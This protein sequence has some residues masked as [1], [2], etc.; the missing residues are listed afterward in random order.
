V[1]VREVFEGD[2]EPAG[3]A[4]FDLAEDLGGVV[5]SC[6]RLF[7]YAAATEHAHDRFIS[8]RFHYHARHAA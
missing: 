1:A 4:S 6:L 2:V 8:S 3:A 5:L 7:G